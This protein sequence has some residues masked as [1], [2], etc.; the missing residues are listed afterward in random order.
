VMTGS[1]VWFL[2]WVG[3]LT[4]WTRLT[5]ERRFIKSDA[6]GSEGLSTWMLQSLHGKSICSGWWQQARGESKILPEKRVWTGILLPAYRG[7]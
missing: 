6:K 4:C 5:D 3:K 7:G 2:M 1:R